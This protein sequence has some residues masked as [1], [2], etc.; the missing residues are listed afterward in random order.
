MLDID[1]CVDELWLDEIGKVAREQLVDKMRHF[2]LAQGWGLLERIGVVYRC[3]ARRS[4]L[5][6]DTMLFPNLR[7][8]GVGA[9]W[10]MRIWC[11]GL[12]RLLVTLIFPMRAQP[13]LSITLFLCSSTKSC[14]F[15]T[16][17]L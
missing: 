3:S 14:P 5:L 8:Q 9:A 2:H 17:C 16:L 15:H 10:K 11:E 1:E 12:P 6:I 13:Q 4:K 7:N